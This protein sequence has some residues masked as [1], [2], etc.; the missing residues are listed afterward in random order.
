MKKLLV[1]IAIIYGVQINAQCSSPPTAN[2]NAVMIDSARCGQ[3]SGGV[4]LSNNSVTGGTAPYSFQ[5]FYASTG[6]PVPGATS[7]S[8]TGVTSGTYSLEIVDAHGC[9]AIITGGSNNFVVSGS[10][11]VI[12]S[13]TTNPSPPTGNIPLTVNFTNTST[14]ASS[15]TWNFGDG[16]T[17]TLV[18]PVHT[19]TATGNDTVALIATNGPCVSTTTL[20]IV[21]GIAGIKTVN[22]ANDVNIYPNPAQNNFT[23]E[24]N[25]NGNKTMLFLFDVN[26][27]LVL[28]QFI[29][30]K[31]TVDVSGLNA[32]VYSLNITNNNGTLTKK[33]VIVK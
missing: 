22:T 5:W 11:E 10:A 21:A 6:M 29:Q 26:G 17:S 15:Y 32:G 18:N 3:A 28:N 8:L 12:A 13:F 25:T 2:F 7:L 16:A 30:D 27:R 31:T 23:I 14:G 24:A 19:Y 1:L 4:T 33:L 9:V 20:T